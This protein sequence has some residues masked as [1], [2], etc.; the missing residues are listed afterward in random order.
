MISLAI[1]PPGVNHSRTLRTVGEAEPR[2]RLVRSRLRVNIS[3][4]GE[5]DKGHAE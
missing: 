4:A 1:T 3:M 5:M 2:A